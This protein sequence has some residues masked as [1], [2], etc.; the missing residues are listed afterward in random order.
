MGP[1]K[2]RLEEW[3]FVTKFVWV[4]CWPLVSFPVMNQSSV[5]DKNPRKVYDSWVTFGGYFFRQIGGEFKIQDSKI[6]PAF[7]IFQVF[8]AQNNIPKLH[9]LGWH[10]LNSHSHILGWHILLLFNITSFTYFSSQINCPS[11]A[12]CV[13]LQEEL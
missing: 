1:Y 10:I 13:L 11:H 9:I 4:W 5:V 3:W 6:L 12:F 2:K 8:T 7:A